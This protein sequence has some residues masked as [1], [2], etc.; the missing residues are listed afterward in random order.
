M[1]HSRNVVMKTVCCCL[2]LPLLFLGT[3]QGT[4]SVQARVLGDPELTGLVGS[5]FWSDPCTWDGF[6]AGLGLAICATGGLGGCGATWAAVLKA[7]LV[8]NCF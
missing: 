5:G 1:F 6:T 3:L 2:L 7:V 8:D 4:L